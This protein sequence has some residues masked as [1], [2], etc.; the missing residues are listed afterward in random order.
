MAM[1]V[2]EAQKRYAEIQNEN[3]ELEVKKGKAQEEVI[4]CS[5]KQ[6]KL[7]TELN[8]I[9]LELSKTQ[10]SGISLPKDFK[11]NPSMN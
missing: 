8:T 6:Q 2:T 7:T 9:L 4:E 11:I 10:K 5:L 3:L 1:T